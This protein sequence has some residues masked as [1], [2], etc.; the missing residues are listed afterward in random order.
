MAGRIPDAILED[1]L[2]RVDIVELVASYIPLK[3]AGRN[4]KAPCPF[5]HEKTPSF[6]VSA[7][8]QIYHCFGCGAGGNA[9]GFLMQ[10]ERLEFPEAVEMLAKKAG[11]ILPSA[12]NEDTAAT[13]VI[14]QLHK[15]QELAAVFY[16]HAL[17][18]GAGSVARA[19]L[20][21][22]G[23]SQETIASFRL[24]FAGDSRDGLLEHLRAKGLNLSL[25]ETSGL[26][27]KR[28]TGGYCD[29]FRNRI[30]F[31]I[32]DVKTRPIGFGGR[33]MPEAPVELAKYVN[34]P[35]TPVYSKG[36]NLY[37]LAVTRDQIRQQDFA[38]VVEGYMDL[39]VPF[40]YGLKNIVASLGTALTQ[41]QARLLK[42]YTHN[43][44]MIYDPDAAGQSAT[45]RSLDTFLE[46]DMNVRVVSLPAGFDPDLYVRKHGI[47]G[48]NEKIKAADDLFDFQLGVLKSRHDIRETTGKKKIAA[49][50][51][52]TLRKVTNQIASADY[53]KKLSAALGI[54]EHYIIEELQKV[55]DT[56]A[57]RFDAA[58]PAP[59]KR[60]DVSPVEKLLI[61]LMLEENE[62]INRVRQNLDPADFQDER[63][64]RIVTAIF[65]FISDGK[66]VEANTLM[67]RLQGEELL[68]CVCESAFGAELSP[69]NREAVVDDCIKRL[70]T[71]SIKNRRQRL[72]DQIRQA[73]R[74]GDEST[75][76]KL[77]EEFCLLLKQEGK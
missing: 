25:L 49:E 61:K 32:C 28:D 9:F 35:E 71:T 40:Q 42:R 26:I 75:V 44:V 69:E 17:A 58:K 21:K 38:V 19:Y 8:R 50:I 62:F 33:I 51:L 6:V 27:L 64:N 76:D 47:K 14:T 37:G 55:K 34:S 13:G 60:A 36:K 1:I 31:P 68:Q 10:Y 22:R 15:A 66:S 11:V 59:A 46:E 4:F 74:S 70:K 63:T 3:R 30:I 39:I 5:H 2:S 43:V 48:L 7:D 72:H 65:E 20:E 29:R 52:P 24:G 67:S 12:R 57:R 45:L 23:I 53:I 73:E 54:A 18:G 41:E 16:E 56:P 77:K